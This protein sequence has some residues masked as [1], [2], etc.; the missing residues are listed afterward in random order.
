MSVWPVK[1]IMERTVAFYDHV[2]L[3]WEL[4]TTDPFQQLRTYEEFFRAW[5][6]MVVS[7]VPLTKQEYCKKCITVTNLNS[8]R[9]WSNL[10]GSGMSLRR[11]AQEEPVSRQML[12]DLLEAYHMTANS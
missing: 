3:I 11:P 6:A 5:A 4:L 12:S 7:K 8:Y 1:I 10:G 9:G 2:P